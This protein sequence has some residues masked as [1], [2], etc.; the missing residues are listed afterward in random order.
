MMNSIRTIGLL[1][2]AILTLRPASSA[3]WAAN[4]LVR[5]PPNTPLEAF[6]V[7]CRRKGRRALC[8]LW[9]VLCNRRIVSLVKVL[10]PRM[11]WDSGRQGVGLMVERLC[12]DVKKEAESPTLAYYY[13]H[14]TGTS[15]LVHHG[16][17]SVAWVSFFSWIF[18]L[19][20]LWHFFEFWW[21]KN[22]WKCEI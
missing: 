21:I 7:I 14:R 3:N 18:W 17:C 10:L 19:E 5:L 12:M 6:R 22:R 1:N 15:R 13:L 16:T 4:D 11:I 9:L 8:N 20:G 2:L